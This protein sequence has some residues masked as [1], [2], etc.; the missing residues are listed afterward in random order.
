MSQVTTEAAPNV[1]NDTILPK[2]NIACRAHLAAYSRSVID[3]YR[4]TP[5]EEHIRN[6]SQ[7]LGKN[8]QGQQL[9][10][11]V[12][13]WFEE[14][15]LHSLVDGWCR[16]EAFE[17]NAL[18]ALI[19]EWNTS[20]G[21]EPGNKDYVPYVLSDEDVKEGV[22]PFTLRAKRERIKEAGGEW[23]E[24]YQAALEDMPVNIQVKVYKNKLDALADSAAANEG[25]ED[26][27]A[28]DTALRIVELLEG[29]MTGAAVAKR[30]AISG[31]KVTQYKTLF[32]FP[33]KIEKYLRESVGTEGGISEEDAKWLNMCLNEFR[34]RV[35][36]ARSSNAA[37][38]MSFVRA[39]DTAVFGKNGYSQA[40]TAYKLLRLLLNIGDDDTLKT[41]QPCMPF[42]QWTKALSD[43]KAK[44]KAAVVTDETE[45]EA[46]DD[47]TETEVVTASDIA[48]EQ[49][50]EQAE[51]R[52]DNAAAVESGEAAPQGEIEATAPPASAEVTTDAEDVTTAGDLDVG[53]G[54]TDSA[55]E[56]LAG[57]SDEP[58]DLEFDTSIDVV[59]QTGDEEKIDTGESTRKAEEVDAQK[60]T[61]LPQTTVIGMANGLLDDLED[62]GPEQQ[63]AHVFACGMM[64]YTQGQEA[65]YNKLQAAFDNFID[66]MAEWHEAMVALVPDGEE[67]PELPVIEVPSDLG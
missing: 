63:A 7:S 53:D 16:D 29:G 6:L 67:V 8:K 65:K 47:D 43:A 66:E 4:K 39:F 19:K 31:G 61:A 12:V 55:E 22:S 41:K 11:V 34:R 25:R 36:L 42:G 45:A 51:I 17:R 35:R 60:S 23:A 32:E 24:K 5:T 26:V 50:K 46:D 15:K 1:P 3:N 28:Y 27:C 57:T 40:S 38:K 20:K 56:V 52:A 30:L 58:A 64:L 10:P 2:Q 44:E 48:D 33:E 13:G 21:L 59:A 54:V 9:Q 18:H 37:I 14:E 62:M 49:A